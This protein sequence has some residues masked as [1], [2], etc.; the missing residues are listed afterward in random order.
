[1]G[2][3]LSADG[4]RSETKPR[5]PVAFFVACLV[6][7]TVIGQYL[8]SRYLQG[9]FNPWERVETPP[10]R[11]VHLHIGAQG[12]VLLEMADGQLFEWKR[13]QQPPWIEV[14][15]ASGDPPWTWGWCEPIVDN[16]GSIPEPPQPVIDR[17]GGVCPGPESG[18]HYEVVLSDSQEIW[19]WQNTTYAPG[20]FF[21]IGG[22]CLGGCG[23]SLLLSLIFY[24]FLCWRAQRSGVD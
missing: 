10:G 20:I 16:R 22:S 9:D 11:P 8:V 17:V 24:A 3:W 19:I 4:R 1:M 12:E 15:E 18:V 14:N 5:K 6:V 23:L 21:L 7:F 13:L 2:S